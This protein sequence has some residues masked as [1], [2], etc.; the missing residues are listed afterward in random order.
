VR[1]IVGAEAHVTIFRALRLLGF[2]AD[3]A[4]KVPADDQGRM[5]PAE[6]EAVL[7]AG[8]GPAIVCAQA[9]NVN[10]GAF[11]PLDE[12][13]AICSAAGAW[14]HVDGAFGLWAAASPELR[15]LL[16][17]AERADSWGV[18]AHK[19]LNVPYDCGIAFTAHPTDHAGAFGFRADYLVFSDGRRDPADFTPEASRRARAFAV[20]AALQ[21]L[22]TSGVA[23]LVDRCCERAQQFASA[24]REIPGVEV[25]NDVVINQIV[26]RFPGLD[27]VLE[28]VSASGACV[29]TPT[30]WQG[31]PGVRISVSN[32]QTTERDIE[33]SVAAIRAAVAER[34]ATRVS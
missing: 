1:I 29:V 9:G 13:A 28:A 15:G 31:A 26:V 22:G 16:R 11:D 2:G 20:W 18:D 4:V 10:S 33:I 24:L 3:T 21:S 14:L 27:G 34:Q 32:W 19:W 17:G 6:L 30:G 23:D 8:S 5:E 7:A 25:A 12:I